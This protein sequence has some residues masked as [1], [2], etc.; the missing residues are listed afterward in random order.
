[1]SKPCD[2]SSMMM[3]WS[4]TTQWFQHIPYS[5]NQTPS[6]LFISSIN[7]VRLLFKSGNYSR[8][9]FIS[10]SQSLCWCR[11]EQSSIEW[12]LDRQGSLL[13]VADLLR[14]F[15]FASLVHDK[16]RMCTCY[17]S[18]CRAHCSYYLR[19]VFISFS[20][21]ELRLQFDSSVWSSGYGICLLQAIPAANTMWLPLT[22]LA[23]CHFKRDVLL[24]QDSLHCQLSLY[25]QQSLWILALFRTPF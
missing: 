14:Y 21:I 23:S 17:S 9:A 20:S 25:F 24:P 11:R 1:M 22:M 18:L 8:V 5:L 13:V 4:L 3:I 12:L 7:F 19:A 15:E 6:L 10:L 16:F 2:V